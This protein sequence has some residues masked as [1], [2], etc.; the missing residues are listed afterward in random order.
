MIAHWATFMRICKY[1][2]SAAGCNLEGESDKHI[3][4]IQG[5]RRPFVPLVQN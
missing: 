1:F 5:T 4:T 2:K 3:N